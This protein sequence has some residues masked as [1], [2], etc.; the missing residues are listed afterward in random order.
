[1]DNFFNLVAED[2][3]LGKVLKNPVQV[4]GGFMHRMFKAVTEQGSYIIKLLNP[5]IMKRPTAMGNY[6]IAD[7]IETILKQNNI[8]AVYA[9]EFKNR[10][11]QELNGQYYYVFEWYDGKSLKDGEIKSV[12]CEKIGE[13]LA[14]IHNIDLKNEPFEKDEMHIDWQKYIELAKDMNSPIYDY[15]KDYADLFNDSMTKVNEAIKKLPPVKA[16]CH[17][18][19]DSKNVLWIGDEFKL[20]DLECLGYSNPYLELFELALCWS[21][22]EGC[23]INFNLFNT[24]IKSY[25]DNTN[26]DTNVDWE[27]L[28]YSNNGRLGWLEYNIKRALMLECD[29]EEEQQLS[30][31]EVKETV[32]H[33]IYYDKVKDEILNYIAHAGKNELTIQVTNLYPNRLIGD[34]HLPERYE[35]DSYGRLRHFPDWY[36]KGTYNQRERV[37]FSPWKHYRANDPLIEAGLIGPV[38]VT[39]K[40]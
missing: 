35:Y 4:T 13:V 9:L 20:I 24:F 10:K 6:K 40:E 28:Y 23:N 22:Y 27:A 12:H 36:Q 15:I 26:L 5:N 2:L 1:M 3:Q 18:D 29:N 38:R 33:I 8:P 14:K 34:E 11:M 31:S 30:I 32:E 19:M 37:L 7:D 21:G 17:N 39:V 16:I 25:F